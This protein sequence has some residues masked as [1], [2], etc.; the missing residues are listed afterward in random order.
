MDTD[1]LDRLEHLFRAAQLHPP[2]ERPAFLDAACADDPAL[3]A[4]IE[5]LLAADEDADAHAFLD[6]PPP[7]WEDALRAA[8]DPL[9]GAHVGPYRVVRRLGQG[10]MGDVYLGLREQ[11]F[12]R[13]VALKVLREGAASRDVLARFAVERQ[14]LAS[15][16][17]P[18]IA[19]LVDGGL[20]EHGLPYLAMDYVE[21]RPV[22]TYCDERRL[23]IPER[24]QLFCAVCDAVH[25]AHQNLVLHRDLK[26]S[27]IL[28]TARGE[29]KLLDFGIAKLL[30]PHLGP[31]EAPVTRAEQRFLTPE[32]ASPEQIRGEP[33]TTA[34]DVYSLGVLL[35]E[36]LTGR[37][38]HR[39]D[40]CTTEEMIRIVSE[41]DPAPPSTA[42]TRPAE[43]ESEPVAEARS[44]SPERLQRH[45]RGDLDAIAMMALRKQPHARYG[46]AELL[47]QDVER[48]LA[49]QPVLARK[50]SRRYRLGMM[51][52]RHRLEATA[53]A[54]VLVA[55]VGGLGVALWQQ[56]E[57]ARERD[58]A[59]LEA[60]KAEEVTAFVLSLFERADPTAAPGDTVRVRDVLDAGAARVEAMLGTQPAVG[61]ELLH[62]IAQA[63]RNLGRYDRAAGLM[64]RA[65]ALRR[66]HLGPSDDATLGTIYALA[67]LRVA[68]GQY[69][70]A[71]ADFR[72][73]VAA[74]TE[75]YGERHPTVLRGTYRVWGALHQQGRA[76]SADSLFPTLLALD[77]ALPEADDPDRA[78]VLG[79]LAY[80]LLAMRRYADAEPYAHR[81]LAMKQRLHGDA[82]PDVADAHKLLASALTQQGR[83]AEAEPHAREAVRLNALLFPDGHDQAASALYQLALTH[84]DL[85][86]SDEAEQ[87]LRDAAAM[88]RRLHGTRHRSLPLYLTT[89]ADLLEEQNEPARAEPVRRDIVGI[90]AERSGE[91]APSTLVA[92]ANLGDT[93]R[94]LRRF[95]EAEPLLLGSY[96]ALAAALG[97]EHA[98]TRRV[99]EQLADLYDAWYRP[100]DAA[101]YRALALEAA[102]L[103]EQ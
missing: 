1:A 86:R 89:L 10:G 54:A 14:I 5:S 49:H 95:A 4:E 90:L 34:S 20:T 61:T 30:N 36:L 33:L 48:H 38:P 66:D 78:F 15:L 59:H 91:S 67:D 97:P 42:V 22:T 45:L 8:A 39:L 7:D 57:A 53:I 31:A 82:H 9:D 16:D 92:R 100:T 37:R 68:Q 99:A 101:R 72:A 41:R 27:N 18:G 40:G 74:A 71:E 79:E 77:R 50:G 88:L 87:A 94:R 98:R 11:P 76:A 43:S 29:V 93:L 69:A 51:L 46:S 13:Y 32:Y 56:A 62:V 60:R 12:R 23:S 65:Y 84:R 81:A 19:R 55:L 47:A 52:R 70:E 2:D 44:A 63:Y 6:A 103:P 25:Y 3:R 73:Y 26:P 75:R 80:A 21:G 24:L 64:A 102:S 58:T 85:S 35:Y 96:D 17:H 28:V 83:P